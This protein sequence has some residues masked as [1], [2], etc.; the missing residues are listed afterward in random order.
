MYK[1]EH[2]ALSMDIVQLIRNYNLIVA[3]MTRYN[4]S[5]E[6][7]EIATAE[8]ANI[9]I[10]PQGVVGEVGFVANDHPNLLRMI[11]TT[12]KL[13]L[14]LEKTLNETFEAVPG[15]INRLNSAM[16]QYFPKKYF[17]LKLHLVDQGIDTT[18]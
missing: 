3:L 16:P 18:G 6:E 15:V 13:L 17:K 10:T 7:V 11:L 4:I 5:R 12:N 8:H 1:K 14:D 9:K 2:V